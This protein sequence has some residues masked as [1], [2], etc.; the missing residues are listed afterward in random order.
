MEYITTK[1]AS[2]KWGIS[3]IRITV[4]ANEGRIPGAQQL[5]RRWL[6]PATATKP[7]ELKP[8]RTNSAKKKDKAEDDFF[9]PLYHFRSDWIYIKENEL[10]EQQQRLLSAESAVLEC[11]FD[12]AYQMLEDIM[13][14]PDDIN[15]E[16]GC[17]WNAGICCVALNRPEDYSKIFLRLQMILSNDIPHRDD[18][19]AILDSLKTYTQ[20]LST[21]AN[22]Y[23]YNTDA[24]EL[25]LPLECLLAGYS[26][27][28]KEAIKPHSTDANLLE[29]NLRLIKNTG[30]V[31]VAEFLH[32]YM[33]GIYYLQ[34]DMS[35][36]EKHAKIAI[37]IAYENKYY[38]PLATYYQYFAPVLAP[39]LKEFPEDFQNHCIELVSSYED[40]SNAFFSIVDEYSAVLKLKDTDFPYIYA[41]IMNL[42]NNEIAER[43]GIS[44][45]TVK[46]KL[47]TI[48]KTLNV[49]SKKE[50]KDFLKNNI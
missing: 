16:I 39:I 50:L 44:T 29:L 12:D 9:F 33:V 26:Q 35:K 30:A 27:L 23:I 45:R 24:H 21:V 18:L 28:S 5:G 2:A 17:L 7:Q 48:L 1:E 42:S 49:S 38:L 13:Q 4:L 41:V 34:N 32:L 31:I 43:M 15:T 36:A 22:E 14:A 19:M 46:R 47:E 37:R 6:I 10:T 8:N 20:T 25:C 40:N 11:R 3:T